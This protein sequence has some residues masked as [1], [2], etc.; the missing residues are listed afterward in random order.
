MNL[1]GVSFVITGAAG[2][3]GRAI[4]PRLAAEGA[5]LTLADRDPAMLERL[6]EDLKPYAAQL[7]TQ[8]ADVT[9]ESSVHSM[10]EAAKAKF[11]GVDVLLNL[12]G[13]SIA[14]QIAEMPVEEY[15]RIIDVNLKATFLCSKHFLQ[16][17]DPQH[18]GLIVNIASVAA[19][20]ANANAPMYCTAKA[21]VAMFSEGL[22]LHAKQK[23][24]RVTTLMPGATDTPFWGNRKVPREKF[25]QV[26]DVIAAIQ[27]V[28]SLPPHV[29]VH[30]LVF[31]SFEFF[32]HK[33]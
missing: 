17:A 24:V 29:V 1:R 26:D 31:E 11:G 22:A 10:F 12:A 3:M 25:M 15:D 28:L 19:K 5:S 7:L 32:K 16:I 18:N 14:G 30:E 8:V 9:D 27:F 13:L 2:G 23:N 4:A 20:Q 33:S 21:A 6:K